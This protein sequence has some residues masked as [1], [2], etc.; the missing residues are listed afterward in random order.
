MSLT[1]TATAEADAF[2]TPLRHFDGVRA[3]ARPDDRLR[4]GRKAALA[5]REQMLAATP[6]T[7]FRSASLACAPY[8]TRYGLLDACSLPFPYMHIENRLFVVQVERGGERRTLLLSPTDIDRAKETPFFARLRGMAGPL[9]PT[10][11][12]VIARRFGTVEELLPR[13]GVRPEEVDYISYDHLHTQDVRRWLGTRDRPG[14]F[15]RAKL[16]VMRQEWE[17]ARG[18]LPTQAD[19]YC[20]NGT[21]D[22]DPAR[23]VLLDGDTLIGDALAL[24]RTPGHTEGN[25]SF[26]TRVDEGL[27]V[28]SEN[29]VCV[30]AYAPLASKI[31]GIAQRARDTGAEVILNGNTL[32]SS[33][34]QYISMVIEKTIAGP[35]QRHAD[36]PNMVVSSE[37]SPFWGAPGIAPTFR[38]GEIDLG[39]YA[40]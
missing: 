11:E 21:D 1:T 19:W 8:P 13:L 16:L 5:L 9:A 31:P 36:F 33:V 34:E 18:L 3:H 28:T 4:A 30:D 26:V 14:V 15:P 25:H 23:V 38:F 35:S 39:V 12:K 37:L 20:P 29:G 40:R 10:F 32:E 6:V 17:S 7:C 27:F 24:V 2:L 22:V